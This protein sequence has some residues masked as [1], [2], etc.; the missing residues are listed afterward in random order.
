MAE[1]SISR[2]L[3][4]TIFSN[5]AS[6]KWCYSVTAETW[7]TVYTRTKWFDSRKDCKAATAE[8]QKNFNAAAT[9]I[10]TRGYRDSIMRPMVDSAI[11]RPAKKIHASINLD[12]I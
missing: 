11:F 9:A 1:F 8:F 6:T 4:F 3:S 5:D 2:D 12:A 7:G 10:E